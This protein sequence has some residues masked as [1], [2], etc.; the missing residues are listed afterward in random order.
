MHW[1]SLT[2]HFLKIVQGSV[3]SIMSVCFC[4]FSL[5]SVDTS[6]GKKEKRVNVWSL[7]QRRLLTSQNKEWKGRLVGTK[8]KWHLQTEQ[9]AKRY[10]PSPSLS[11]SNSHYRFHQNCSFICCHSGRGPCWE[12]PEETALHALFVIPFKRLK[13][14][15]GIPE[16]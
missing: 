1:L 7:I 10:F 15:R 2:F 16:I 4:L 13:N 14:S 6:L 3:S 11:L 8:G 5:C 12:F 9:R